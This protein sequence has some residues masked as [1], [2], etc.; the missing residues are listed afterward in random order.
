MFDADVDRM[1]VDRCVADEMSD[2]NVAPPV[3]PP[4]GHVDERRR[5]VRSKKTHTRVA[6]PAP[7][8]A[9]RRARGRRRVP[10]RHQEPDVA[11]RRTVGASQSSDERRAGSVA[12]AEPAGG[13]VDADSF[14]PVA[15]E[16]PR[17]PPEVGVAG[18]QCPR[19]RWYCYQSCW[20]RWYQLRE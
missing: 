4:E 3:A 13:P 12:V 16:P 7:A 17:G 2:P 5:A 6:E 19:R 9:D 18:W 1:E 14:A 10:G 15:R 8:A 20:W 11:H